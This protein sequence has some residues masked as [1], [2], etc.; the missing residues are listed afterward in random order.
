MPLIRLNLF[1]WI[2]MVYLSLNKYCGYFYQFGFAL[3]GTIC[4]LKAFVLTAVFTRLI[5]CLAHSAITIYSIL[6]YLLS[7]FSCFLCTKFRYCDGYSKMIVVSKF[8]SQYSSQAW[9]A[10]YM[11]K[12]SWLVIISHWCAERFN[13]LGLTYWYRSGSS[14][15]HTP[16]PT[17]PFDLLIKYNATFIEI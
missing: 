11:Y 5:I 13:S 16:S 6:L 17:G 2:I 4:F 7:R 8:Y 10:T 14:F 15:I 12:I 3:N 1:V 9:L